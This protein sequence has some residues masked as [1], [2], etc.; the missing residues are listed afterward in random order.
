MSICL[1][2]AEGLD[3]LAVLSPDPDLPQSREMMRAHLRRLAHEALDRRLE[4]YESLKTESQIRDYQQE[5]RQFFIEQ[6]EDFLRRH[7]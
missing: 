3:E 6:L 4:R 7:P 1:L 5:M 2:A